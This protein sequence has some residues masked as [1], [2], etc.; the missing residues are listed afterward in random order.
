MC[1]HFL[2]IHSNMM[3]TTRIYFYLGNDSWQFSAKTVSFLVCPSPP[4]Q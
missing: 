1:L 3:F 4:K 2:L